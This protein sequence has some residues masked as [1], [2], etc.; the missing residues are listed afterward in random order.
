MQILLDLFLFTLAKA[1]DIY[2]DNE[3]VRKF[4]NIQRREWSSIM[5]AFLEE[6]EEELEDELSRDKE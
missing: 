6:A 5:S 3:E 4:Y 2:Y 1:E